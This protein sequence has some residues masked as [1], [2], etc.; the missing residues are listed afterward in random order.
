MS[1]RKVSADGQRGRLSTLRL[2]GALPAQTR[3]RRNDLIACIHRII[4]PTGT[5]A[6][7]LVRKGSLSASGTGTARDR[8]G[9]MQ[10][11]LPPCASKTSADIRGD[12]VYLCIGGI[13]P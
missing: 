3:A 9:P 6:T 13:S 1:A 2:V 7:R 12:C 8:L 10:A 5:S 11:F 4:M